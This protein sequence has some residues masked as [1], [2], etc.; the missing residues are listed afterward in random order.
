MDPHDDDDD[1]G[2][3]IEGDDEIAL[4]A[5]AAGECRE[6]FNQF[7]SCFYFLFSMLITA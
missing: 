3:M 7:V 1:D 6:I 5:A 4:A 2:G